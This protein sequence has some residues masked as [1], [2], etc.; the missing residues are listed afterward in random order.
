MGQPKEIY[1]ENKKNED[2]EEEGTL[3][4]E[5]D[6]E[7]NELDI[8]EKKSKLKEDFWMKGL[9]NIFLLNNSYKIQTNEKLDVK[10]HSSKVKGNFH[11]KKLSENGKLNDKKIWFYFSIKTFQNIC[12][13]NFYKKHF[14]KGNSC[15]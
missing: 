14:N 6:E 8:E 5:K 11:E 13:L 9:Q 7:N 15:M 2:N 1:E 10:I 4:E 12:I 3:A